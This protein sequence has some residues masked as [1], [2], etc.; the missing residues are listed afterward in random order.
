MKNNNNKWLLVIG[1]G[2]VVWAFGST[3]QAGGPV[4]RRGTSV[5]HYMTRNVL[6][7]TESG[8]NVVGWLRLQHNEQGHSS[9]QSLRLNVTGLEANASYNLIAAVGDDTNAVPVASFAANRRGRSE[10][11]YRMS[12]GTSFCG[13]Y[14]TSDSKRRAKICVLTSSASPIDRGGPGWI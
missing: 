8:S 11:S 2:A 4:T 7:A 12:H 1:I 13:G 5:M 3:A 6:V 14:P 9:K 10:L